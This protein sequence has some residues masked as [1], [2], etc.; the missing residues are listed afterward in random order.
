MA[1]SDVI[2]E[3]SSRTARAWSPPSWWNLLITLP[4]VI[5]LV[6]LLFSSA[7]DQAIAGREQITYGIIRTHEP[8]NHNRFGYEFSLS[9]RPFTGWQIPTRDFEIG[10]RV[11][12][13]YDPLDPTKSSLDSFAGA[14]D[15]ILGPAIFCAVGTAAVVVI[16]FVRRRA[17]AKSRPNDTQ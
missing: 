14:T 5:G 4:W 15:R 12:V 16:I 1:I 6:F 2:N 13:Y 11:L 7:S 8:A 9:G 10:Q 3:L 17:H